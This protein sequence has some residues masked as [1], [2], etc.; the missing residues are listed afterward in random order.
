[1]CLGLGKVN[2][3]R[4]LKKPRAASRANLTYASVRC[5]VEKCLAAGFRYYIVLVLANRKP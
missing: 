2:R 4:K 3:N 1:M 5:F